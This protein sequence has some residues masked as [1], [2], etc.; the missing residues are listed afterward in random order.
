MRRRTKNSLFNKKIRNGGI[1]GFYVKHGFCKFDLDCNIFI[2]LPFERLILDLLKI[3]KVLPLIK[4]NQYNSVTGTKTYK[5][6]KLPNK[7]TPKFQGNVR[8]IHFLIVKN[9][10]SK[11]TRN[12]RMVGSWTLKQYKREPTE[13]ANR[14]DSILA[15]GKSTDLLETLL[16]V[17]TDPLFFASPPAFVN[18]ILTCFGRSTEFLLIKA[19][20]ILSHIRERGGF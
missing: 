14:I 17:F 16:N 11:W 7:N 18:R 6:D 9:S 1:C 19:P 13:Y 2:L 15:N 10:I 4:V 8:I 5:E 20:F 12:D 3:G